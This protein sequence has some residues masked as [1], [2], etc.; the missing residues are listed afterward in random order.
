MFAQ[1]GRFLKIALGGAGVA[2]LVVSGCATTAVASPAL[3]LTGE[4]S[5]PEICGASIEAN[6][7]EAQD[8]T[9][10]PANG[11]T[12]SAGTP[13]VFSGESGH[14]L[15]FSVASSPGL[16]ST[17]D[18]DSGTG[19][20]SGSFYKFTAT[21]ATATL[22]TVYWTASFTVTPEDCPE[23]MTYTTPVS[24]LIVGPSEAELAAAKSKQEEEAK[25]TKR[26]QEQEAKKR[27]GEEAAVGSVL[28][29]GSTIGVKSGREAAVKLTCS[30]IQT[31]AGELTL[32]TN[33]GK[34][35]TR[36]AKT[37]SIGT[38]GF[39]IA[40]RGKVTV[41]VPL[42]KTARALLAAAHGRLGATLTIVRITPLPHKTQTQRVRLEQ[43]KAVKAKDDK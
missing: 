30:D 25:K 2:V 16:L 26:Q 3:A 20:E 40:P 18:I 41:E 38:A 19:V 8:M 34:G 11:A 21:N 13:V 12:V 6:R 27:A 31:C 39:S 9:L 29:D 22:R 14:A 32:T 23:P 35:K 10:E 5:P 24:T 1:A 33:A 37:G 7:G 43:Q 42:D 17:P 4:L 28:L 15:T 36:H